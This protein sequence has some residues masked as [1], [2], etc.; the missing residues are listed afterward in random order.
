MKAGVENTIKALQAGLPE[1]ATVEVKP[2]DD[3]GAYVLVD[4]LEIGSCFKPAKSWVAFHI[5]W[6]HPDADIYPHFIDAGVEYVG[7]KGAPNQHPEGN[8]PT[9][10][11]RGAVAPGF[12]RPAIQVSRRS[13]R[14]NPATDSALHKLLRVLDFL[15][16]R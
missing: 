11:S 6:S 4:N 16:S 7:D 13:N 3:G 9:S 1:E 5:T 15:R 8:L 14:R 2:D 10:M 12:E